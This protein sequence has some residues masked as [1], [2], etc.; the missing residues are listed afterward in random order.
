MANEEAH[1]MSPSELEDRV[2]QLTEKIQFTLFTSWNG[3]R[4]QQWPLTAFV[5]PKPRTFSFLVDEKGGRY[6]HLQ[7]YPDVVLGFADGAGKYVVVNGHGTV[8]NDRQ[9]IQELWSPALKLW[10]D[11]AEDP[12]IRLL[13][14]TPDRAELWDSPARIIAAAVM[15]TA[16]VTGAKPALGD[17]GTV[18]M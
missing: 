10:W 14:V 8:S 12:A 13:T 5:E 16:A 6:D 1:G 17:H 2:W 3:E 9:K 7:R 11:S 15:L 4:M 18:R